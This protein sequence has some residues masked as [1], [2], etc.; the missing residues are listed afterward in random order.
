MAGE[1]WAAEV[2]AI[3]KRLY[4]ENKIKELTNQAAMTYG[5]LTTKKNLAGA[6]DYLPINTAANELGQGNI[7]E[8]GALQDG[9]K[10]TV[11]QVVATPKVFTHVVGFTGLSLNM[12]KGNT[13]SFAN[14]LTYNMDQAV[15]NASKELNAQAFRD[16]TNVLGQ[17]SAAGT[18]TFVCDSGVATHF[19]PGM[20]VYYSATAS[21]ASN[22]AIVSSV[23]MPTTVN[24]T[25]SVVMTT[26]AVVANDD[27]LVR[28]SKA[29][30]YGKG[31]SGLPA[32][33]ATSGTFMSVDKAT[34]ALWQGLGIAAGSVNLSDAILQRAL[35]QMLVKRNT[36]P[37]TIVSNNT[38]FRMYL[39]DTLPQLRFDSKGGRD[40]SAK[41]QYT[42]NGIDWHVDTDC[43]FDKIYMFDKEQF[44]L[45]ENY[46]LKFDD[47]DGNI[48]KYVDGYDKFVAYVKTYADF[49]TQN[50]GSFIE[51][52]GLNVP[53]V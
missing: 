31:L 22:T 30:E 44:M 20:Q 21:T 33:V 29:L 43:G 52:S 28:G 2:S 49:G 38:Q 26:A 18:T 5:K 12:L 25:Y 27:Y 42:W 7:S 8:D 6:G 16:G 48:L 23:T 11:A 15:K 17:A 4:P 3:A 9:G 45:F 36:V 32:I 40:S 37:N 53:I 19:R 13:E 50:C 14:T 39:A 34:T 1:T 10:Q 35:G 51:I 47:S 41:A 46:A 24:G